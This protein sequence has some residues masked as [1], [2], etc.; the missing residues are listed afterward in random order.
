MA[1]E[2]SIPRKLWEHPNPKSTALYMFK[3]KAEKVTSRAFPVSLSIITPHSYQIDE[4]RIKGLS[5]SLSLVMYGPLEYLAFYLQLLS[6][7]VFW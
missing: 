2:Y 5:I 6:D 7:C 3:K 4:G 1:P